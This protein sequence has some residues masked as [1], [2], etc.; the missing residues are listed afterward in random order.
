[1]IKIVI[2]EDSKVEGELYEN[3]LKSEDI[4]VTVVNSVLSSIVVIEDLQP[5]LVIIDLDMARL[6]PTMLGKLI[7]KFVEIPIIFLTGSSETD[8]FI[9]SINLGSTDFLTKPISASKLLNSVRGHALVSWATGCLK[10][11]MAEL[12]RVKDKYNDYS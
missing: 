2:I 7:K 5:N 12:S 8:T 9:A 3:F 4:D 6:D 10:P 1:M 11:A